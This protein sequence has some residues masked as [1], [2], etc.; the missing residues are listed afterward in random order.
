MNSRSIVMLPLLAAALAA[1]NAAYAQA[2]R[3]ADAGGRNVYSDRPCKS[4][5]LADQGSVKP[6]PR[7]VDAPPHAA[8]DKPAPAAK[9]PPASG[10]PRQGQAKDG[11]RRDPR[12]NP[13]T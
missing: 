13:E 9:G 6:P 8:A 12:G 2:Y 5:G 3:C 10:V 1:A 4:Q 7:H 11:I